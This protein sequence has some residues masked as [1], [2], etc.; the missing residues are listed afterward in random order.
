M[1]LAHLFSLKGM[2]SGLSIMNPSPSCRCLFSK[3]FAA[4]K[5][6]NPQK[7]PK[8]LTETDRG[9]LRVS[10]KK[11]AVMRTPGHQKKDT[12]SSRVLWGCLSVFRRFLNSVTKIFDLSKYLAISYRSRLT[13]MPYDRPHKPFGRDMR[14]SRA[15]QALFEVHGPSY[16]QG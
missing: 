7:V 4:P 10:G 5:Q 8:K 6:N 2:R 11:T 9:T 3:F 16:E 1:H 12:S 13:R 14:D 15:L